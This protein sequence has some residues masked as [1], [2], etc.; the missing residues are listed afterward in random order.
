MDQHCNGAHAVALAYLV[1]KP[2]SSFVENGGGI[3]LS[4][5]LVTLTGAGN[6]RFAARL[7]LPRRT[8]TG[9]TPR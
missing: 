5:I 7:M 4:K 8:K 2:I 1:G 9:G 6:L 3:A